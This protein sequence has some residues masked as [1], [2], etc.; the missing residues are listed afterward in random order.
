MDRS[1]D[2]KLISFLACQSQSLIPLSPSKS[3]NL[4]KND[5]KNLESNIASSLANLLSTTTKLDLDIIE[6][7]HLR[8]TSL[9]VIYAKDKGKLLSLVRKH[10]LF[11]VKLF[12][13]KQIET[14]FVQLKNLFEEL[15]KLFGLSDSDLFDG[16]PFF[17]ID[18]GEIIQLVVSF[19]F[20]LLQCMAQYSSKNLKGIVSNKKSLLVSRDTFDKIPKWQAVVAD[21]EKNKNN[22]VKLLQGFIK[23]FQSIKCEKYQVLTNCLNIKLYEF[24]GDSSLLESISS[25]PE[26]MPF[27]HDSNVDVRQIF[28]SNG[29]INQSQMN[30]FQGN[31]NDD[32]TLAQLKSMT[33]TIDTCQSIISFFLQSTNEI[34]KLSNLQLSILDSVTIFIKNNLS[35]Q[36][37]PLL[38]QSFDVYNHFHQLKRMRNV[39]NLLFN[40][41]NKL[42][43][44][45]YL[46]LSVEYECLILN[47]SP[48]QE[49]FKNLF[50]K[51][52]KT[53]LT[54]NRFSIFLQ[55]LQNYGILDT[56]TIQFICKSL[57]SN[58]EYDLNC[59]SDEFKYDLVIKVFEI[60]EKTTNTMQK[61]LVCNSIIEQVHWNDESL[62]CQIKYSYYNIN[63]LDNYLQLDINTNSY[64]MKAGFQFQKMIVFGWNETDLTLGINY[65]E[66][67]VDDNDMTAISQFDSIVIK[68]ILLY[69]KFNG[70]TG[71]VLRLIKKIKSEYSTFLKFEYC[72][73][74]LKLSM[75]SQL[76]EALLEFNETAKTW[77]SINDVI[78]L[79]LLQF[80]YYI[81]CNNLTK[82]KERFTGILSTLKKRPEFNMS[83]SKDL[84]IVQKFQNFLILGKFQILAC[85]LNHK[86]KNPTDAFINVKTGIQILYS[87]IKKCPNNIPKPVSQELK[88]EISHLLFDAYKLA[89]DSL[90]HLGISR[91]VSFYL[92][93]WVK[94]NDVN[95]I[96]IVNT[97]NYYEI[98]NYGTMIRDDEFSDYL[99]K[100]DLIEFDIVRENSTVQ[101]YTGV[102]QEAMTDNVYK[103]M[104][105][106]DDIDPIKQEL[107]QCIRAISTTKPFTKLTD[108]VQILPGVIGESSSVCPKE[109][110]D[111]LVFLKNKMLSQ[112]SSGVNLP[113]SE[114]QT[115]VY[116]LN[117]TVS[118]LS[119]LAAFKGGDLLS[120][121]YFVQ[122]FIKHYPFA[123][124]R[125]LMKHTNRKEFLPWEITEDGDHINMLDFNIDLKSQLPDHWGIVTIDICPKTG[126]LLLSKITKNTQPLF[127]RLPLN[128]LHNDPSF[129]TFDVIKNEL[130]HVIRESNLS[131]KKAVTSKVVTVDDRKSWWRSRFTLDYQMQDIFEYVERFWFGGFTG[132]F[133]CEEDPMIFQKF[134]LDFIKVF[135]ECCAS[136]NVLEF[137][138]SIYNLFYSLEGY[139]YE[140]I[141][142]LVRYMITMMEFHQPQE[143]HAFKLEKFHDSVKLL[144][145][146]YKHLKNTADHHIV[147]IPGFRCSFFPW[148]SLNFLKSKSIS[149]MPSVSSLLDILKSTP[150]PS[151]D[152]SNLYYL[153]NP[154]GDL[155]RTEDRF[156]KIFSTNI[157]WRG[158]IGQK[159]NEEEIIDDI[160]NSDLFVYIGHGGCNQYI[161]ES[162]MFKSCVTKSLP[163]SLLLGC[164]SG[165]LDSNGILEPSGN[166]YNW[167]VCKSPMVLVNLWDVTDKDI[168]AFTLSVFENWGLTKGGKCSFT[169]SV[170]N[171]RSKCTLKYLNGS[172]PIVYGLPLVLSM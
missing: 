50:T 54:P 167:L 53:Q 143:N 51:L 58:P 103:F 145:D 149:R 13:I 29:N 5:I 129:K 132:L 33:L 1:L 91:D 67:W 2:Q 126:D 56:L 163:P 112:L 78:N 107:S 95:D 68:Q 49:N 85:Q 93:E 89:I 131:T 102:Y 40:L 72:H 16:V 87:I 74:L 4:P 38:V 113:L 171:S 100:A 137:D 172:A 164:S 86:L 140:A 65:F 9:Y 118:V 64:L 73:A 115:L 60:M 161:K 120:E 62:E 153:I 127:V 80:E 61:T 26:L 31:I 168:D 133:N 34:E 59:I 165:K 39:S 46:N 135:Q 75:D 55:S 117:Q 48:N 83:T 19:H 43:N 128:R 122:D 99:K 14:V 12:E 108:S 160:L 114:L 18:D 119:S 130:E 139:N 71:V 150:T 123:N 41:G 45:T 136:K 79:S 116:Q 125:K 21:E 141:N 138:D 142:D 110:L 94:I 37:V 22:T 57:L 30:L 35:E 156:R 170:K 63:G 69:L 157:L 98:G 148:E 3:N 154:G 124:E 90:I 92:R 70:L 121:F 151:I 109:I 77:K 146:K 11:I 10:Q 144:F 166:I 134:K 147:L 20:L 105:V 104:A 101:Y 162:L 15:I 155:T 27:V 28:K 82:A 36:L 32:K 106:D 76:S 169:T 7:I 111:E 159:P 152:K 88:W 17:D 8:L 24:T 25:S 96:P 81:K 42:N 158:I 47:H 97:I 23:L 6:P 66:S 52:G 84:S 44:Q